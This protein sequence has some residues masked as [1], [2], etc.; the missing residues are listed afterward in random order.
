MIELDKQST[1]IRNNQFSKEQGTISS[2]NLPFGD[3]QR[4]FARIKQ[5]TEEKGRTTGW[6]QPFKEDK[7]S[8]MVR[9]DQLK[10][11]TCEE[12]GLEPAV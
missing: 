8:T 5:F 10:G 4:T 11:G 7:Q 9:N 3:K 12:H 6:K 2:W 1:M